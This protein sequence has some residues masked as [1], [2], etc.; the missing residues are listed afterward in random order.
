MGSGIDGSG[1][2]AR[3]SAATRRANLRRATKSQCKSC[4]RKMATKRIQLDPW[5]AIRKCRFCGYEWTV[6]SLPVMGT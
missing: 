3:R 2:H 5:T 1:E 4:K 6:Q